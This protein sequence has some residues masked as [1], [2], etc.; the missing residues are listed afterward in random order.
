[1]D[2]LRRLLPFISP[3]RR[4]IAL[5]LLF[6]FIVAGLW[7]A[8][9]TAVYP[10]LETL[11]NRNSL[12]EHVAEKIRD[13]EETVQ[14]KRESLQRTEE[15]IAAL[16]REHR[17]HD[18]NE[19][20]KLLGERVNTERSLSKASQSLLTYKQLE[21]H[22]M[23]WVPRNEFQ[24]FCLILGL[25]LAAEAVKG[26]FSY[27]QELLIG[28]VVQRV[29]M[30]IRTQCLEKVLSLDYQTLAADGTGGLMSRFTYDTEQVASGVMLIG[31]RVVREPLKCLA[32]FVFAMWLN[33][34]LTL[35]S[36]VSLPI[37]A[38]FLQWYGHMLRRASRRMMESM[39]RIYKVLE[40]TLEGLKIV[41]VFGAAERHRRQFYQ[42]NDRFYQKAM[43]VV[44]LDAFA[45]PTMEMLGLAAMF[46]AMLPGAYLVLRQKT[47]IWGVQ[48][49]DDVIS[50]P[51][52]C[53]LYAL[54]I[55][56]LDPCRKMSATFS[57]LKRCA[58]ALDRL[59]ELVDREP[60]VREIASPRPLPRHSEKIEFR[61]VTFHYPVREAAD[62]RGPALTEVSLSVRAGEVVALVGQ[63]GCGK[64][65]LV[66]MLPR[67]Y[68]PSS[69]EVLIDGV[70]I[71]ESRFDE[72]RGQIGVVT[73][74]TMLFDD[75]IF[76]NIRYGRP[77]AT[78]EQVQEAARRAHV[79]EI[80]ETLP[81]G[82]ETPVGERG[83]ELSGGQRQRVALARAIVR[84]PAIL[85]LDEA[86]SAADA[87]S[88]A[89]ILEALESFVEGRT[90]F[91]ITHSM[92]PSLIRLVDRV[93]V[94]QS[95]RIIA[96]GT[97]E[98]LLRTCS[99]YES[100]YRAKTAVARAA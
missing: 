72:L 87:Q 61:N 68:D 33:W 34:R 94:M 80:I 1:M 79:S 39:S 5:S 56:M 57:R 55:G 7:G 29:I 75:T 37:L 48:L 93:V 82:Y 97:H 59:Y 60:Q 44:R 2:S 53:V 41:I 92:T 31:T 43:R 47:D 50:A 4:R 100:L 98:D 40:E 12:H 85:I 24:A 21:L 90:V 36:I 81:Q 13:A 46:L 66:S 76:E 74:E 63:N 9:L 84:D 42:E 35:L 10:V 22:V 69:G 77:D 20:V 19:Y 38:L 58:A 6:G 23:P 83:K 96:D 14:R 27:W 17:R 51:G 52:L 71:R 28:S 65:T 73:Q 18:D 3:Y 15:R 88:E 32:C 30:G 86:T 64:S 26:I 8:N 89:F 49:T 78:R 95:G 45:K 62:A 99:L 91:V 67:L 16:E 11:L 54:L 70:P 25:L